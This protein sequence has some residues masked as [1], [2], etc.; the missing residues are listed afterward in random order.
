MKKPQWR[1]YTYAYRQ[2]GWIFEKEYDSQH[3]ALISIEEDIDKSPHHRW[4][5]EIVRDG[6]DPISQE[7]ENQIFEMELARTKKPKYEELEI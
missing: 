2:T 5:M 4:T 6:K 1:Y 7:L 3:E